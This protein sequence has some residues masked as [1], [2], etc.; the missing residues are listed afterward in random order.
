MATSA[1]K[2]IIIEGSNPL[3]SAPGSNPVT[4]TKQIT[5]EIPANTTPTVVGEIVEHALRADRD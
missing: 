1:T 2:V 3:T 4:V 5:I